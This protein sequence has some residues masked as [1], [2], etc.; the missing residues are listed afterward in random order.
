[1]ILA[2]PPFLPSFQN[3]FIWRNLISFLNSYIKAEIILENI[4]ILRFSNFFLQKSIFYN[5]VI[6]NAINNQIIMQLIIGS[7]GFYI[8]QS[9][10]N[11]SLLIT[12]T[13]ETLNQIAH[14]MDI[15]LIFLNEILNQVCRSYNLFTQKQNFSS[16]ESEILN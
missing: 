15:E 10:C 11:S 16:L 8:Y 4:V 13:S 5:D 12:L 9:T 2:S 1:M 3:K 7:F 14:N 6:N